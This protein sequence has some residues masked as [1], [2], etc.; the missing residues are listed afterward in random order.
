MS[1]IF[2]WVLEL[3]AK[4]G[5]STPPEFTCKG[6]TGIQATFRRAVPI[7]SYIKSSSFSYEKGFIVSQNNFQ[8]ANLT[9]SERQEKLGGKSEDLRSSPSNSSNQSV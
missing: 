7:R 9:E 4:C 8:E 5:N 3:F 2:N 1:Q 6:I